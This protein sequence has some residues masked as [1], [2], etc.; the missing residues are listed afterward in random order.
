MQLCDA[1]NLPIVSLCD[2]RTMVGPAI[3]ETGMV[4]YAGRMFVAAGG[5]TVPLMTVVLRKGYGLGAQAMAGGSFAHRCSPSPGPRAN[6]A[7][8]A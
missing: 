7:A 5:L 3:E 6:S 4:R 8:W 1:F 2:A